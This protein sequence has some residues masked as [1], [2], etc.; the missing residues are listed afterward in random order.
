MRQV[1][2]EVM[3][4][5]DE[6]MARVTEA[7]SAIRRTNDDAAVW[8]QSG[9]LRLATAKASVSIAAGANPLGN[10]LDMTVMVT[11]MRM[12]I[13]AR[14]PPNLGQE[15]VQLLE[16][17]R[18][19]EAKI[20]ELAE[21]ALSADEVA[22]LQQLVREW[23][24]ENNDLNYV[25]MVR[26]N[27]FAP[28]RSRAAQGEQGRGSSFSILA[29][30]ALDPMSGLDP[31]VR[32]IEQSRMLGERLVFMLP[33]MLTIARWQAEQVMLEVAATPDARRVLAAV[34]SFS[35]TSQRLGDTVAALPELFRVERIAVIEQVSKALDEQREAAMKDLAEAEAPI[36]SSLGAL[37]ETVVA[38]ESLAV[39]LRALVAETGRV[40][41]A[42]KPEGGFGG[43]RD[44]D[45]NS[46]ED[47][48]A[49]I[50]EATVAARELTTLT[51]NV[52]GLVDDAA[53][54]KADA[55]LARTISETRVLLDALAWRAIIVAL[56][57][58]AGLFLALVGARI[59]APKRA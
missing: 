1:Q 31:T 37:R 19:S 38:A 42:I 26:L 59:V 11:L 51:Q 32:E 45:G 7:T 36:T 21:R 46:M 15:G 18:T 29:L 16:A 55:G 58:A 2:A 8:R 43:A 54:G 17:F 5:S 13:E 57:A 12:T 40:A 9:N 20:C 35:E 48:R 47:L 33:R 50:G 49:A 52:R 6:L 41:E 53:S 27:D 10:L 23:K 3:D 30:V 39:E 22:Q 24:Y 56:V 34:E 44:S 4:F 14:M 28:M 25:S